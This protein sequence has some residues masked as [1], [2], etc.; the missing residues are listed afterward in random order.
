MNWIGDRMMPQL[1]FVLNFRAPAVV[2]GGKWWPSSSWSIGLQSLMI[3]RHEKLQCPLFRNQTWT[4]LHQPVAGL[5]RGQPEDVTH[6]SS[7]KNQSA[8]SMTII[9]DL[10]NQNQ[11]ERTWRTL[12][13][14]TPPQVSDS[15]SQSFSSWSSVLPGVSGWEV[16]ISPADETLINM[17]HL[18]HFCS[19]GNRPPAWQ[20]AVIRP[21][22]L[23]C[24]S[25]HTTNV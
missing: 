1:G 5:V 21:E 14:S 8:L 25:D 18:P 9:P 3:N 12:W 11:R 23:R 15:S 10:Y 13:C 20:S 19:H 22:L 7:V 16:F 17:E 4:R 6:F 2:K 24:L